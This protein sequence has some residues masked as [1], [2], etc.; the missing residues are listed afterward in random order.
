MGL[1][2]RPVGPRRAQ[3]MEQ[4]TVELIAFMEGWSTT[5]HWTGIRLADLAAA[6][7][8]FSEAEGGV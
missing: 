5:Q 8:G 7:G 3:A 2:P 1:L 6:A 4:H